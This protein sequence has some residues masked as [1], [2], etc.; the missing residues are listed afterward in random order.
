MS[1]TNTA[2]KDDTAQD[3][4]EDSSAQAVENADVE[5]EESV[6]GNFPDGANAEVEDSSEQLLV[7]SDV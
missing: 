1:D 4:V 2:N 5:D 6:S 7:V 3:G